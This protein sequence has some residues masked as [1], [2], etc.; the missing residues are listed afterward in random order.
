MSKSKMAKRTVEDIKNGLNLLATTDVSKYAAAVK[1]G[2]P[3]DYKEDIAVDSL[4]YIKQL[5]A[6]EW[7][8]FD[9]LSSA[10]F[11]KRYYFRQDNGTVYSRASCEYLTLD[12]AIDEFAGKLTNE[13]KSYP[14]TQ[15][16]KW[17]NPDGSIL[18]PYCGTAMRMIPAWE[19][20]M[21]DMSGNVWTARG[22]CPACGSITPEMHGRTAK[23]ANAAAYAAAQWGHMPRYGSPTEV[24]P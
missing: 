8:L 16:P 23:E 24:N 21:P 14:E 2:L 10:W 9:L 15:I 6:R 7:D 17:I 3:Y 18:C 12:Q 20:T 13:F 4:A 19:K 22:K 1:N 5:E 11:G